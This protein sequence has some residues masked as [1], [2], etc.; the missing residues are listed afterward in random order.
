MRPSATA[1]IPD[2]LTRSLERAGRRVGIGGA[3]RT[4]AMLDARSESVGESSSRVV[5]R[6][7]GIPDPEPQFEIVDGDFLAR[8][9]FA[10][11][12]FLTIGEFDGKT[13]VRARTGRQ[14]SGRR[15]LGGED[16]RG[17]AAGAGLASRALG[18]DGPPTPGRHDPPAERRIR[19]RCDP[20]TARGGP[21]RCSCRVSVLLQEAHTLPEAGNSAGTRPTS[22][23]LRSS[24]RA[25]SWRRSSWRP[26]SSPAPSSGRSPS[27]WRG[28]PRR[29]A[30][31][32]P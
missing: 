29:C 25:S 18:V 26:T 12:E 5:F 16:S 24:W 30:A 31:G 11:S 27:A 3:R 17:P 9:D 15:P 14:D 2:E 1:S 7:R 23:W 6:D 32:P 4:I 21:R 13:Q 8:V 19:P 20:L 22:S 10:W 28:S